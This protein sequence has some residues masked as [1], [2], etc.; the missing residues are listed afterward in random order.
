MVKTGT[1]AKIIALLSTI[2]TEIEMFLNNNG[3]KIQKFADML[4]QYVTSALDEVQ[5]LFNGNLTINETAAGAVAVT[6][7]GIFTSVT[8]GLKA[9]LAIPLVGPQIAEMGI[10]GFMLLGL[11]GRVALVA[12]S[13]IIAQLQEFYGQAKKIAGDTI[14]P[15]SGLAALPQGTS[16]QDALHPKMQKLGFTDMLNPFSAKQDQVMNANGAKISAAKSVRMLQQVL[17]TKEAQKFLNAN[18][19]ERKA[20]LDGYVAK[21]KTQLDAVQKKLSKVELKPSFGMTPEFHKLWSEK[22]KIEANLM[23]LQNISDQFSN[24]LSAAGVKVGDAAAK[25]GK[26]MSDGLKAAGDSVQSQSNSTIAIYRKALD[27]IN[28]ANDAFRHE[29]THIS[30]PKKSLLNNLTPQ[31]I[32]SLMKRWS[33]LIFKGKAYG[34]E[35]A[36]IEANLQKK[37]IQ[38][39]RHDKKYLGKDGLGYSQSDA[40]ASLY[41][42]AAG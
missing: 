32:N 4:V 23:P 24:G 10:V 7:A 31:Q 12:A 26:L 29:A 35:Y 30:I 22:W 36:N 6:L 40:L 3:G 8:G 14:H 1:Q 42:T 17:G 18:L 13:N 34:M 27:S 15:K 20:M 19:A 21:Y 38:Y 9:L 25:N 41:Q 2:G 16:L 33:S 28:K 11:K 39:N 37:L 5:A